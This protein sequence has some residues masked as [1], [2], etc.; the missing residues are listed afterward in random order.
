MKEIRKDVVVVGGGPSGLAATAK[1]AELGYDVALV[2]SGDELGGILI[3]CIHDGFGTKLFGKALSGPEFAGNF[4]EKVRG[5]GTDTF[6]QRE[7]MG[8]GS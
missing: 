3:Q 2:E 1:L 7:E 6:L 5:L 8:T 4:I